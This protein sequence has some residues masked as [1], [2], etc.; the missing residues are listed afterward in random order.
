MHGSQARILQTL[1]E[2]LAYDDLICYRAF[3][4]RVG[5]HGQMCPSAGRLCCGF[6][7]LD[8]GLRALPWSLRTSESFPRSRKKADQA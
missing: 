6:E 2:S 7:R 8:N 5:V 4:F 1:G 3:A